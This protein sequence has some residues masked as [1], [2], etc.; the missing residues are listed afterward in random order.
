MTAFDAAK[1]YQH[2]LDQ[3]HLPAEMREEL[4]SLT[5]EA[6]IRDRFGADLDFGTG[7]LR[8]VMGA[9]LNRMNIY[10]VRRAT[11][12]LA[13]HLQAQGEDAVKAGVAIGY[14]CRHHSQLFAEIAACTLAAYGIRAYVAPLLCPTPELSWAVRHLGAAAGIMITASHNPPKYNGYK[15]YNRHGGQLLEDDAHD[16]KAR[17]A[18]FA[19]IFQVPSLARDEALAKGLLQSIP[20]TVRAE[21]LET[22]V[23]ELRDPRL[24]DERKQLSIV[25][26]PLHGT[27]NVPVREALRLAGYEQVALV[28][29]Q[30]EPN[31]DF[32]T[33]KSPNPEEGEALSLGCQLA[34]DVGADLVMG[35]DPDADRVGIAARDKSGKL[36][37]LTGNQVGA[38]LVDYMCGRLQAGEQNSQPPIVFKTIVT[39][40]FGRAIAQ[41]H[42]VTVEE[43]LTASSTSAIALRLMKR[44]APIA[45]SSAT[46]RAMAICFRP[47]SATRMLSK[48]VW[49][50]RR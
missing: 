4:K 48:V 32:P 41:A 15:V 27:G 17:M 35:T 25:Y 29:P 1:E 16:I 40:D 24:T 9:G 7:G 50:L 21:Y 11:A 46:R 13:L 47:L 37:L 6:E 8:G 20:T 18:T 19:D 34:D 45:C 2:W 33:V 39:S 42:G 30:V 38:L 49:P 5:N 10:T 28:S 43:T 31:G 26:T 23:R 44:M 22:V 12:G 36:Q 3:P 14:D